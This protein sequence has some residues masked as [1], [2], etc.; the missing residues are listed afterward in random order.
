[1]STMLK[2]SA[3]TYVVDEPVVLD[4]DWNVT[5]APGR[6]VGMLKQEAVSSA[7]GLAW[8]PPSYTIEL[9][10]EQLENMG[11]KGMAPPTKAGYTREYD[12]SDQVQ[13]G[14]IKVSTYTE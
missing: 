12:I 10:A 9:T 6:Y 14:E 8:R 13:S 1:M 3:I 2:R 4:E 11:T 5:L 7:G